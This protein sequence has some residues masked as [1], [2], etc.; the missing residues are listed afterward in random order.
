MS[1]NLT[2]E[3]MVAKMSDRRAAYHEKRDP[4]YRLA[5]AEKMLHLHVNEGLTYAVIGKRY[6]VSRQ[7]V[8]QLV[9]LLMKK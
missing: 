3:E 6:G 7:R 2:T 5:T 1:T 8:Y 9:S 4:S